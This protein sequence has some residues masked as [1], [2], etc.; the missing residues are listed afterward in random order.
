MDIEFVVSPDYAR[1]GMAFAVA[2]EGVGLTRRFSLFKC[3]IAF[4]CAEALYKFPR[5]WSYTRLWLA[6]DFAKSRTM[7]ASMMTTTGPR[8]MWSRNGGATF[9]TW[10]SAEKLRAPAADPAVAISAVQGTRDLYMRL[11]GANENVPDERLLLSK[12]FGATWTQVSFGRTFGQPGPRGSMPFSSVGPN[13]TARGL[14]TAV[15]GGR[16]FTLGASREHN[17][18]IDSFYC[19]ADNGRTWARRCSR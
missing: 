7:F 5:Q 10:T 14:L 12:D 9:S 8:L 15:G 4:R 16:V 6:P 13:N 11:S 3:D 19:T 2:E 17:T 18:T 1:D